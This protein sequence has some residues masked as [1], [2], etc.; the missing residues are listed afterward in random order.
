MIEKGKEFRELI[1]M[2]PLSSTMGID[3][4]VRDLLADKVG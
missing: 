4:A 2:F 1:L 3:G